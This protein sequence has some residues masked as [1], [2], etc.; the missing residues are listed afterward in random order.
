VLK[1]SLTGEPMI[2]VMLDSVAFWWA[3][4]ETPHGTTF[5]TTKEETLLS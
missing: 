1:A 2:L 3:G 5:R 4:Q